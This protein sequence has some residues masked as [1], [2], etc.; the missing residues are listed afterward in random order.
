MTTP[1]LEALERECFSYPKGEK[2]CLLCAQKPDHEI[3]KEKC[4]VGRLLAA[5]RE[6]ERAYQAVLHDT[7]ATD[8]IADLERQLA[9]ARPK[10]ARHDKLIEC[11]PSY[12]RPDK[13]QEAMRLVADWLDQW[14]EIWG[15]PDDTVQRDLRMFADTVE[16]WDRA[17]DSKN[18]YGPASPGEQ[19][20]RWRQYCARSGW[21]PRAHP[22]AKNA[23]VEGYCDGDSYSEGD[24]TMGHLRTR[25]A[26][27][28]KANARLVEALEKVYAGMEY[29][30]DRQHIRQLAREWKVEL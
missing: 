8:R 26:A 4:L 2:Y 21:D 24:E 29:E 15:E 23:Y 22:A 11:M 17:L 7:Q 14:D 18:D 30:A 19:E 13:P 16:Q 12:E 27:A 6:S 25:L 28:E 1:A 10:V 20:L 9:E 3:H 5:L